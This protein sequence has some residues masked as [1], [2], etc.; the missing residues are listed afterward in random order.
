MKTKHLYL[1]AAIA[2]TIIPYYHFVLFIFEHG[3]DQV[4]FL[5]Q[6]TG[7][8]VASFFTWDVILSSAAVITMVFTEG[9]LK[10]MKHLWLYVL[11]NL[12]VGVSLALPAFLYM[13]ELQIERLKSKKMA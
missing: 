9:K 2:G 4:E 5:N 3:I 7:S 10:Q 13:R 12:L 8:N 1:L 11:F 6:M